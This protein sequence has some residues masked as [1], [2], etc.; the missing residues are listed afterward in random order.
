[1]TRSPL[2]IVL[3]LVAVAAPACGS[4]DRDADRV[5]DTTRHVF[6]SIKDRD[7]NAARDDLTRAAR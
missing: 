5:R 7:W 6:T 3:A 1:M 2:A 4:G